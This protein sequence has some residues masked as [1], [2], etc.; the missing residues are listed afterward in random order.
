MATDKTNPTVLEMATANTNPIVTDVDK[1]S[2]TPSSTF[3]GIEWPDYVVIAI[4]FLSVLAVGIY[5]SMGLSNETTYSNFSLH[6]IDYVSTFHNL[7]Q[8][9]WKSKRDSIGGYFLASRNMHWI[10]VS[11]CR[12][13]LD[14]NN[15]N[16]TVCSYYWKLV[17]C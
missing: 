16:Q 8:S 5:V 15:M 4:Y 12:L 7:L 6:H 14:L 2:M 11:P 10:P 13:N 3:D 1:D 17:Q 9:S